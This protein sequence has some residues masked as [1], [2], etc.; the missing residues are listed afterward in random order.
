M[1]GL[2][3]KQINVDNIKLFIVGRYSAYFSGND[4]P[5]NR[6]EWAVWFQ[7]NRLY[8]EDT[9]TFRSFEVLSENIEGR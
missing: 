1:V 4:K 3:E 2:K 6:V 8:N 9:T 5:D 7:L